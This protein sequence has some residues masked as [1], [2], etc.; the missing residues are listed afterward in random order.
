MSDYPYATVADMSVQYGVS[1]RTLLFYEERGF[2]A[3]LEVRGVRYYSTRDRIL[4][5][6]ILKG[7]RLGFSL[8]EIWA[9]INA[10]TDSCTVYLIDPAGPSDYQLTAARLAEIEQERLQ[11]DREISKLRVTSTAQDDLPETG[12]RPTTTIKCPDSR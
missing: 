2:L 1:L 4:L 12:S 9:L 5:E 8:H 11:L 6:L 3:P 7:K 10:N